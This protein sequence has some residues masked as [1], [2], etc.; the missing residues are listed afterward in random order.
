MKRKTA[1]LISFII[2]ALIL[3]G[4]AVCKIWREVV[5]AVGAALE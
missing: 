1:Q 5:E 4:L 3:A 2:P